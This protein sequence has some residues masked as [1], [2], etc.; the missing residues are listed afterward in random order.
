MDG[1]EVGRQTAV[2]GLNYGSAPIGAGFPKLEFGTS[3]TAGG[4]RCVSSSCPDCIYNMNPQVLG[5]TTGAKGDGSCPT[6]LCAPS[7]GFNQTTDGTCGVQNGGMY[8][9]GWSGGS[10]MKLLLNLKFAISADE[11][12]VVI[13]M[14]LVTGMAVGMAVSLDH[15][16]ILQVTHHLALYSSTDQ[17][18]DRVTLLRNVIS[19]LWVWSKWQ[20]VP[21]PKW[22][23]SAVSN[24]SILRGLEIWQKRQE[25][26]R[27]C[28]ENIINIWIQFRLVLLSFHHIH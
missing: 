5:L 11:L 25:R 14:E 12:K 15:A 10:C 20:N 13:L 4:G 24:N 28:S 27:P 7:G 18:G 3:L 17:Y 2:A 16:S 19:L 21:Y 22:T 1:V 6:T 9:G 23:S 26:I 8:C